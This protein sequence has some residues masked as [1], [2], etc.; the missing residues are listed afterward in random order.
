M[1]K[2]DYHIYTVAHWTSKKINYLRWY[3]HIND[4]RLQCF[5][6]SWEKSKH[7]LIIEN[8]NSFNVIQKQMFGNTIDVYILYA[9]I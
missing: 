3:V 1:V 5:E 4:D 9:F 2:Q 8:F 7:N 6:I